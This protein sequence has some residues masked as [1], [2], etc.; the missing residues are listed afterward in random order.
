MEAYVVNQPSE[1]FV[2]GSQLSHHSYKEK[3]FSR[4]FRWDELQRQERVA[5]GAVNICRG[6]S[7]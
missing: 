5:E 4:F 6:L 2:V 7:R 1:V 3:T